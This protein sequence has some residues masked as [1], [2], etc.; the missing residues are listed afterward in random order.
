M[1]SRINYRVEH[2]WYWI[3]NALFNRYDRVKIEC[4]SSG[5]YRDSDYVIFESIFQVLCNFVEIEIAQLG[6]ICNEKEYTRWQ[7]FQQYHLPRSWHRTLSRELAMRHWEWECE[8]K[9]QDWDHWDEEKGEYPDTDALS[10]QAIAA[11]K[12]R[13]LYLWYRDVRPKRIDADSIWRYDLWDVV[14]TAEREG[15]DIPEIKIMRDSLMAS[16]EEEERQRQEDTDMACEV[17]KVRSS[18]WT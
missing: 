1:I 17:V 9:E 10:R 12:I 16:G 2:A 6:M 13:E 15:I 5:D 4:M 14:H 7:R 11:R 3:R 8:L 18:M